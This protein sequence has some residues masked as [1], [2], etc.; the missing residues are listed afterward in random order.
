MRVLVLEVDPLSRKPLAELP[1]FPVNR[2]P[3]AD[4]SLG[5]PSSRPTSSASSLVRG[6]MARS[7]PFGPPAYVRLPTLRSPMSEPAQTHLFSGSAPELM[8][9]LGSTLIRLA[10]APCGCGESLTACP[11]VQEA[12]THERRA[13]LHA[14]IAHADEFS[15]M[16]N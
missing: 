15:R 8:N 10:P 6:F 1:D 4:K 5:L 16:R 9:P 13:R 7:M 12:I 2:S 14:E 11:H 3:S